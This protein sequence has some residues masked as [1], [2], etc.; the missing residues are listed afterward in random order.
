MTIPAHV[1][2]ERVR[3]FDIYAQPGITADLQRSYSEAM[4]GFPEVFFTPRNGG[5]WIVRRLDDLKAV[6]V[7]PDHFSSRV[8]TIPWIENQPWLIPFSIDPP[9]HFAYRKILRDSFS[10]PAVRD[11]EPRIRHH[12]RELIAAVAGKQDI[13]FIEEV[14]SRFPVMVFMELM[15]MPFDRLR[16]FR[17]IVDDN[18]RA[19]TDAQ[20]AAVF[21][22]IH[23]I[24]N[25][26]LDMRSRTPGRDLVSRIV[27]ADFNGRPLSRG[28][29]LAMCHLLFLGGMDTVTNV[30]G[31]T[32]RHLA[33]DAALQAR[34]DGDRGAIPDFVNEAIRCFGTANSVRVVRVDCTA[35]G[36]DFRAG[37]L[38]LGALPVGG[39]DPQANPDPHR[40][41]IARPANVH[42]NV[43]F[44]GGI[45]LCLGHILARN[46]IRIF[47]EEWFARIAGCA[48]AGGDA[49]PVRF[50][51]GLVHAIENLPLRLRAR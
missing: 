39:R 4:A 14:S 51:I 18:F 12:A 15:G 19:T 20:Y 1:P 22:R 26:L 31:F 43:T 3:D 50:R 27:A 24:M 25:D 49:A 47:A 38:I 16:E 44:G 30:L 40:F 9:D 41:D 35:L 2:A 37:D 48:P 29:Q 7:D 10:P 42:S 11:L 8:A 5:H 23:A 32:W 36:V 45:H 46:E 17:G 34:L 28:E 21:V 6:L 33:S 13:D